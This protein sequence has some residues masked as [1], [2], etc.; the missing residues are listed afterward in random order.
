MKTSLE[1]KTPAVRSNVGKITV[2]VLVD[3]HVSIAEQQARG[4]VE[5]KRAI[6]EQMRL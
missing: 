5:Q 6:I 4:T 3:C 2:E 1:T